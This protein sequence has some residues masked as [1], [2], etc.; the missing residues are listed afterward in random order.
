MQATMSTERF[1]PGN[2]RSDF[3][4]GHC[5]VY[6]RDTLIVMPFVYSE[7]C[8]CMDVRANCSFC[9]FLVVR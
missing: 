3:E 8:P 2:G 7:V 9:A 1:L 5:D 6:A 4:N